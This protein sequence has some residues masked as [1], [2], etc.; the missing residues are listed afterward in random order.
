MN[1]CITR[2]CPAQT[3]R[4]RYRSE[5]GT[6][7]AS[8]TSG[9]R[10]LSLKK[11]PNA[12]SIVAEALCEDDRGEQRDSVT[13][14]SDRLFDH[15]H[16]LRSDFTRCGGKLGGYAAGGCEALDRVGF[17]AGARLHRRRW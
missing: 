6:R 12:Q 4:R 5:R 10:I 11:N 8:C 17:R 9:L 15:S 16:G 1:A 3:R 2:P 7:V 14:Q 13:S